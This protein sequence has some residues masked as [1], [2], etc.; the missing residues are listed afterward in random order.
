MVLLQARDPLEAL[1]LKATRTAVIRRGKVI[2]RTQPRIAQLSV[3]GRPGT[4]DPADYAPVA[5][6][7]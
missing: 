4:V 2:A 5:A 6:T 7:E 1:R 3:E